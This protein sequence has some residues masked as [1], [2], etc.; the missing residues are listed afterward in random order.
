[1]VLAEAKLA[2]E[3]TRGL[4]GKGLALLVAIENNSLEFASRQ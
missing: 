4:K 1:V 3:E 2:A